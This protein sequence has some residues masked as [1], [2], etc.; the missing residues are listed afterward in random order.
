MGQDFR[1]NGGL[2]YLLLGLKVEDA[3]RLQDGGLGLILSTGIRLE[4][5][6]ETPMYECVVLHIGADIIVG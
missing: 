5:P 6:I 3:F 4:V 2:L 1:T